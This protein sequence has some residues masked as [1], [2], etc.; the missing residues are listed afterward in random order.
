[1]SGLT[2]LKINVF[3]NEFELQKQSRA[4]LTSLLIFVEEIGQQ[5]T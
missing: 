4:D 5:A 3:K 2:I 1:M